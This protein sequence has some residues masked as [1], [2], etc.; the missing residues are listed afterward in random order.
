MEPVVN[1]SSLRGTDSVGEVGGSLECAA[2]RL[3]RPGASGSS[4]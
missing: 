1:G 2:D 3:T 4:A